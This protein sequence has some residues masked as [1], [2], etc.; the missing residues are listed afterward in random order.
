MVQFNHFECNNNNQF[1]TFQYSF[2]TINAKRTT[3]KVQNFYFTTL[4]NNTNNT[5]IERVQ[6]FQL[7]TSFSGDGQQN[8]E[9]KLLAG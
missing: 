3:N 4:L 8:V 2:Y 1:K 7:A 5:Y 9:H 6:Y